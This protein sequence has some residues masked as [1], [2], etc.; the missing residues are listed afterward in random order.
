MRIQNKEQVIENMRKMGLATD[1]QADSAQL[2][3]EPRALQLQLV[4]APPGA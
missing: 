3:T 2:R 1:T 4:H